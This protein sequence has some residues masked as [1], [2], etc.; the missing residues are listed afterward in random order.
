MQI[1]YK[2]MLSWHEGNLGPTLLGFWYI[3]LPWLSGYGTNNPSFQGWTLFGVTFLSIS[4][5]RSKAKP[6]LIG[7]LATMLIGL[8][9]F[10]G[11]MHTF[12]AAIL[13][14]FSLAMFA[15]V[16]VW[17]LGIIHFGP[18]NLKA[19][20]LLIVP[21]AVLGFAFAMGLAGQNPL[22]QFN[23]TQRYWFIGLNYLAVML[24]C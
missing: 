3:M 19:E 14:T 12:N 20:V 17:E 13:W 23:W 1:P 4:L 9:Y 16:L 2:Q 6:T 24:F 10:F 18:A 8:G 15:V 11:F 7:S 5:I 22:V 21:L